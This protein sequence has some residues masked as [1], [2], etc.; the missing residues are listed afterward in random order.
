MT[1]YFAAAIALKYLLLTSDPVIYVLTNPLL[2]EFLFGAWIA[3]FII[4]MLGS[5]RK[6]VTLPSVS[7]QRL[8]DGGSLLVLPM[9]C[10]DCVGMA[11]RLSDSR[12]GHP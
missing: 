10:S 8:R 12:F 6:L 1:I 7:R 11:Q 3:Y 4:E 5:T 9:A 2:L